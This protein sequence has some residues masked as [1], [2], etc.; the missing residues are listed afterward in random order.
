MIGVVGTVTRMTPANAA[1]ARAVITT[2]AKI[3]AAAI[4]VM[5]I[6]IG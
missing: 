6:R 4:R 5:T 3:R 1:E 2:A